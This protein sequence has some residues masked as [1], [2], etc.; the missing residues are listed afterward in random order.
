MIYGFLGTEFAG[1]HL[2][3]SFEV[4]FRDHTMEPNSQHVRASF[5]TSRAVPLLLV[6][7]FP[8]ADLMKESDAVQ[9]SGAVQERVQ[10][11]SMCCSDQRP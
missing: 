5:P 4:K 3:S 7:P 11:N 1:G 2:A 9:E 8:I 6:M 10:G